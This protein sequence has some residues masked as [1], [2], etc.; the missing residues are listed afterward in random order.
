MKPEA[1][2]VHPVKVGLP[3]TLMIGCPEPEDVTFPQVIDPVQ[4]TVAVP[5]L[6]LIGTFGGTLPQIWI[7]SGEAASADAAWA[8]KPSTVA[9]KPR[10]MRICISFLIAMTPVYNWIARSRDR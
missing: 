8:P 10:V 4:V 5:S 7:S 3:I 9:T 6:N 2:T 1:L